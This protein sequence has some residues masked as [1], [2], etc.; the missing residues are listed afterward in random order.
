MI[1][2][3]DLDRPRIAL[4]ER[5][6]EFAGTGATSG[7]PRHIAELA[8]DGGVDTLFLARGAR[9]WAT[10]GSAEPQAGDREYVNDAVTD[11]LANGGTVEPFEDLSTLVAAGENM[12]IVAALLRHGRT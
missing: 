9:A 3:E 1:V 4:G 8:A 5:Y 12:P 11:T 10:V 7:D 6:R 2:A